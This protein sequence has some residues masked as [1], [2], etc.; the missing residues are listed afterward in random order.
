MSDKKLGII[1]PYRDRLEH[2]TALLPKLSDCLTN[3]WPKIDHTIVVVEQQENELFNRGSLKNIGSVY[4]DDC[5]Y[6]CFHDVDMIPDEK[7]NN[8]TYN[9]G[10]TLLATK[11]KQFNYTKPYSTY[12]GGVVLM[13]KVSYETINGY[14]NAYWFWGVEDDDFYHRCVLK[15]I[16]ITNRNTCRFDSFDHPR[17][18][19]NRLHNLHIL[20][21]FKQTPTLF[22][23]NGLNSLDYEVLNEANTQIEDVSYK[24][25]KVSLKINEYHP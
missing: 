14:S 21:Q 18:Q 23:T 11:V 10:A 2:L 19:S 9:P 6:F 25:V 8:Y 20:N 24:H 16:S 5:D 12:L 7:L 17:D 15:D 1:I 13:D 3:A 4:C 22:D